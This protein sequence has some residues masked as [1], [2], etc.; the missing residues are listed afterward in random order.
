[1]FPLILLVLKCGKHYDG[2]VSMHV[3]EYHCIEMKIVMGG[4]VCTVDTRD[5]DCGSHDTTKNKPVWC[6]I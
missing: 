4:S 2:L 5:T 1:M 3:R 6:T